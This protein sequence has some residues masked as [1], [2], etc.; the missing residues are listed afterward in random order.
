MEADICIS[1]KLMGDAP[2]AG[3]E[4]LSSCGILGNVSVR[5]AGWVAWIRLPFFFAL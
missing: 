4:T 1:F 2:A 3:L 5:T